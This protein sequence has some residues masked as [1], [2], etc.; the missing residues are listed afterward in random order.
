M[1]L[2]LWITQVVRSLPRS[3]VEC[4][5]FKVADTFEVDLAGEINQTMMFTHISQ[6]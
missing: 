2:W 3:L 5:S 6:Y 4:S 1:V